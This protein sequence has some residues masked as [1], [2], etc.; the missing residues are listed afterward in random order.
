MS[1]LAGEEHLKTEVELPL[2]GGTSGTK[3]N[4]GLFH[5][6]G[7]GLC[8]NTISFSWR[9]FSLPNGSQA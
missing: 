2:I 3:P 1:S 9:Y 8:I 4:K 6:L 7:P 5:G